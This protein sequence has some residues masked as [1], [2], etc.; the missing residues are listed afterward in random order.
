[1]ANGEASAADWWETLNSEFGRSQPIASLVRRSDGPVLIALPEPYV[2]MVSRDL[3]SLST[4]QQSKLRLIVARNTRV[5]NELQPCVLRYDERLAGLATAPGGANSYFPQRA[6]G[7]FAELLS[8]H[9]HGDVDI[10]THRRWVEAD[11]ARAKPIEVPKRSV[12]TDLEVFRWIKN[13][14]PLSTR[15]VTALLRAFREAGRA[16]E[17]NRFRRLVEHSRR[18]V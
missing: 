4:S 13:V 2:R 14:D 7:H 16:C 1:M 15:S 11:L 12:Q 5:P 10:A 6:L 17:Q 18:P 3:I 9:R 8:R